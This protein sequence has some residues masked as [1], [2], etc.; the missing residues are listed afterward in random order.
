MVKPFEE[1]AFA[2]RDPGEISAPVKTNY[3]YHIIRLDQYY[4]AAVLPFEEIKE[5]ASEQ[6]HKDYI[7]GYRKNYLRVT[8]SDPVV[9]PDGAAEEMA[10]RYFGE[11]LELAPDMS[12]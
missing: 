12:D 10:K 8:L 9:I 11:N 7:D 6:A 2:L 1:T 5:Q 4:P 3:G